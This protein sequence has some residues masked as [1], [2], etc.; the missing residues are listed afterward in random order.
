MTLAVGLNSCVVL[1]PV[2]TS[3]RNAEIIA[4]LKTA[5]E[6]CLHLLSSILVIGAN[7][8]RAPTHKK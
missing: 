1:Q 8:I 4:V 2:V 3:T 5:L 7:D 6:D